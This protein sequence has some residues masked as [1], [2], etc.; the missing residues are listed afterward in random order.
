VT[1]LLVSVRDA[2]EA[3][4][5]LRGG[6][7]LIDV[8]EPANGPLG[9]ADDGVIAEVIRA[10]G[11][12]API[13]AAM[14]ELLQSCERLPV[15]SLDYC[16]WGLAGCGAFDWRRALCQLATRIEHAAPKTQI[17]IA[18]YADWQLADAPSFDAV[19]DFAL[20][21]TGSL[22]LV[23]TFGKEDGQN[24]LS[25]IDVGR[26]CSLCQRCRSAG[27]CVAIAGS[28]GPDELR[29]LAPARPD[30]FAVRGSVCQG[31]R[32]GPVSAAKVSELAQLLADAAIR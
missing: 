24:L 14:G 19:C 23:D 1:R 13:S 12:K 16:K 25:W 10:V 11:E 20:S 26:I 15:A 5:A 21:R 27:T 4:A 9:K 30:W 29:L 17:V 18:A 28:L 8:K 32:D 2:A 31:G 22:V 7:A 6:A 3:E